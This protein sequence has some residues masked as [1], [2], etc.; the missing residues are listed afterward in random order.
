M[1]LDYLLRGVCVSTVSTLPQVLGGTSSLFGK[2][3]AQQSPLQQ[4]Q[5][6]LSLHEYLSIGLLKEAGISVPA[7]LVAN[8]PEEAYAVAKQIGRASPP[9]RAGTAAGQVTDSGEEC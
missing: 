7:G 3:K 8:T 5:R 6:N 1:V 2:H 4:Q 9:S